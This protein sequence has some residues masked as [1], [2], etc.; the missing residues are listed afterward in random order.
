M[1]PQRHLGS[2]MHFRIETPVVPFASRCAPD[3]TRLVLLGKTVFTSPST[4]DTIK[5]YG[6]HGDW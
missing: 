1:R 3:R 4:S 2:G 5:Q 6:V